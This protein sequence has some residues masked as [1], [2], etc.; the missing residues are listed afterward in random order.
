[1]RSRTTWALLI[2][3]GVLSGTY[4]AVRFRSTSLFITQTPHFMKINR[5]LFIVLLTFIVRCSP[6][7]Y[8][9]QTSNYDV[10]Y[11]LNTELEAKGKSTVGSTKKLLLLNWG[12]PTSIISD[13]NQGEIYTYSYP[14]Q[15]IVGYYTPFINIYINEKGIIY[16]S[17]FRYTCLFRTY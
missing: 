16:H 13:G 17:N 10:M 2:V 9:S 12:P 11:K 1:M 6:F 4:S 15:L 14:G 7:T 5:I 8:Q 3:I